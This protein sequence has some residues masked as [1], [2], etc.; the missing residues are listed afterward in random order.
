MRDAGLRA[1][2]DRVDVHLAIRYAIAID[3]ALIAL[4]ADDVNC[5]RHGAI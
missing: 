2:L 5:G 3:Y 1:R 4:W